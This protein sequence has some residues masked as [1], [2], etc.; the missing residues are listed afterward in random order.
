MKKGVSNSLR[1]S[2]RAAIP[3]IAAL[4]VVTFTFPAAAKKSL[5]NINTAS[6][7]ELAAVKGV[8]A[9]SAGKIIANRPYKSLEE[10]TKA[11][12]SAKEIGALKH[13]L[14]V[15]TASETK[16]TSQAPARTVEKPAAGEK[17]VHAGKLAP[18]QKVNI[19]SADRKELEKLPGIGSVKAQ[20]IIDGR[21][22]KTTEDLMKVKGIKRGTFDRIKD[23]VTVK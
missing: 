8:G 4:L 18:G 6:E 22:Y 7:S 20:A 1:T 3:V 9:V 5:V 2:W 11:G 13:H 19:N 23:F 15:G 16:P 12:F 14:T 21:P 17:K 10:L